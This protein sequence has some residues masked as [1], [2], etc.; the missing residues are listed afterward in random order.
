MKGRA[1][2]EELCA[3][4]VIG[5]LIREALAQDAKAVVEDAAL[6]IDE[7]EETPII[8]LYIYYMM[9][10]RYIYLYLFI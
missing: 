2:A 1:T 8:Y 4:V 6:E 10:I 9:Y 5:S 3:D 7:M